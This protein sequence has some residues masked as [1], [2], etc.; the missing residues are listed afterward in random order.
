MRIEVDKIGKAGGNLAHT[1]AP[2]ELVLD[3]EAVRLTGA[4][5]IHAQIKKRG[6]QVDLRGHIS[7]RAEVDCDRCLKVVDIPLEMDF[8]ATYVPAKISTDDVEKEAELRDEDLNVS[9]FDCETIDLDELVREQVLLALPLHALCADDCK[10]LCP[11][12]GANKNSNGA[13]D[14]EQTEIDP[15]WSALRDLR[16]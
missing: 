12:C 13:C 3:D 2:D 15:R 5:E 8:V 7:A 11:T 14:C 16:F 9:V 1:Y 4:P 6:E 10:G